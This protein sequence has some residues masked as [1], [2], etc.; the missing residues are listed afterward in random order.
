MEITMQIVHFCI[1]FILP[2][3]WWSNSIS[4]SPLSSEPWPSRWCKVCSEQGCQRWWSCFA[5]CCSGL[6]LQVL[7]QLNEKRICW[8][9]K[10]KPPLP[11]DVAQQSLARL[12]RSEVPL[13]PGFDAHEFF[14]GEKAVSEGLHRASYRTSSHDVRYHRA[15]DILEPSGFTC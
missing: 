11:K 15:M 5:F 4:T 3:R 1:Y 14:A 13:T 8:I 10:L 12:W 2:K 6:S 7:F 9:S